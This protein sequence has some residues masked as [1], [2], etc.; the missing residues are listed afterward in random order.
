MW[1]LQPNERL[2]RWRDFR[3]HLNS[4]STDQAIAETQQFWQSCPFIP[5]YL[6]PDRPET[7]PGPWQLLEE[8]YYCD[9]A[10]VLGIVYTLYLSDHKAHIEFEIRTYYDLRARCY[11]NLAW[12]S[13]GK[14]VINLVDDEIVNNTSIDKSLILLYSYN[15]SKLNLEKY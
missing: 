13:S 6:E 9:L 3:K 4:L 12:L 2:A 5:Y 1:K 7:W 15:S 14:Y 11:Y 10:K 8:N